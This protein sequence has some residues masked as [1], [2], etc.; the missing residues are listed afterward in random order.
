MHIDSFGMITLGKSNT[1]IS[2]FAII[3][4]AALLIYDFSV[5]TF[6][7]FGCILLHEAGHLLFMRIYGCKVQSVQIYPFGIDIKT[8]TSK[9]S[10]RAETFIMLSGSASNIIT[11]IICVVILSQ[12]YSREI[13]FFAFLNF[14]LGCANLIPISSL[15]GG[16]ALETILCSHLSLDKALY[17]SEIV[18]YFSYAFLGLL[19]LSLFVFTGFNLSFIMLLVYVCLCAFIAQK[20]L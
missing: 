7:I 9:I 1:K 13:L 12:C 4:I 20:F 18:S 2:V 3:S 5:Y 8:D 10:Y 16:R 19:S 15:D 17:I 6:L 14:F 11:G